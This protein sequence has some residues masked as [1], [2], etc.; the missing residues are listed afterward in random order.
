MASRK[1]KKTWL[2][3]AILIIAV[4]AIV[5][6]AVNRSSGSPSSTAFNIS[7]WDETSLSTLEG[8]PLVLNF[9]SISC[10]WCKKQLPYLENA[11]Q[12]SEGEI[13]VVAIN[14]GE[15]AS[16]IQSFF[17]DYEPTM[18]VASDRNREAFVDYCRAYNNTKGYIPFT[19]FVDSEGIVQ[20]VKIG[21]F[22]SEAELWDTLHN[23]FGITIPQTP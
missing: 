18:I 23:V 16:R 2:I 12:Q 6:I 1:S 17:G 13:K 5:G 10:P 9:W 8:T 19:L 11:A 4:G 14:V 3:V 7:T 22:Q 20:H 21:A 15:S